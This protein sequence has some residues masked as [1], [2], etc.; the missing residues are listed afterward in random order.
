[1][2]RNGILR[3][4]CGCK[5]EET[6]GSLRKL[7]NENF[8]IGTL[9]ICYEVGQRSMRWMGHVGLR[10]REEKYIQ[11]FDGETQRKESA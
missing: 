8:M 11:R 4:I 5:V 10:E 7:H 9:A 1:M 6:T 3:G 2:F